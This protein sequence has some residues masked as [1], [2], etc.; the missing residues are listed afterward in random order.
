MKPK[1]IFLDRDGT[2]N[3]EKHYI[4]KI[5]D[6]EFLPNA[7]QGLKLLQRSG[8]L[9]II[10]TNQ[11]GIARG[12]FSE[13]AFLKLNHWMISALKAQGVSISKVYYCPHLCEAPIEQYRLNCNCRKP[14]LGMYEKAIKD[15]N[16]DLSRS[17]VIGDRIRDCAIC[18]NTECRGY[19]ISQ[20]EKSEIIENVKAGKYRNLDYKADL[21]ECAKHIIEMEDKK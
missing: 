19:L 10:I 7:I 6:F 8:Y 3:V 18:K 5:E 21:N 15:F 20:T 14:A 9:L 4:H 2:I 12:Y 17:F 16:I 13:S 11:S 1:A